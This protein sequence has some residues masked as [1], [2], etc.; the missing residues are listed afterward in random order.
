MKNK[1]IA[2]TL[3]VILI[4]AII[5]FGEIFRV[6]NIEVELQSF[7]G[8]TSEAEITELSGLNKY[9]SIFSVEEDVVEERIESAYEGNAIDVVN[10][11]RCFPS[12]VK[13]Y[14]RERLPIFAVKVAEREGMIVPT[15]RQFQRNAIMSSSDVD[16]PLINV[17]GVEVNKSF[18]T[19]NFRFLKSVADSFIDLGMTEEGLA[20]FVKTILINEGGAEILLNNGQ[21]KFV[22]TKNDVFNQISA[23]FNAY[24][25]LSPTARATCSL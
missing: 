16:F 11:E 23:K 10:I 21:A 14:V 7:T 2:I 8:V 3:S 20:K 25:S 24:L 18:N 1:I 13:L 17:E 4:A 12:K 6:K 15:D 5:A 19:E 9:S 22:I